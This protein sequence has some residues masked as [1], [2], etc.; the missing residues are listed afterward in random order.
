[1]AAEGE[2]GGP[3]KPA[4][5]KSSG[6][7]RMGIRCSD[8][9]RIC[10]PRVIQ[11]TTNNQLSVLI[12]DKNLPA[13]QLIDKDTQTKLYNFVDDNGNSPLMVAA[14][15]PDNDS[16]IDYIL[17]RVNNNI[18]KINNGKNALMLA[19]KSNSAPNVEALLSKITDFSNI[20]E[21]SNEKKTVLDYAYESHID[22]LFKASFI[23]ELV[24]NQA[25][26]MYLPAKRGGSLRSKTHK[27]LRKY[28]RRRS[29]TKQRKRR[30][31]N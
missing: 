2:L 13:I 21:L 24:A 5:W 29:T 28:N 31:R 9:D 18:F 8:P 14:S 11:Q 10:M 12:K 20:N 15:T 17:S 19:F 22:E 16:I 4:T 3:C 27:R 6:C 1:M 26:S 25:R 30:Q 7:D 23:D